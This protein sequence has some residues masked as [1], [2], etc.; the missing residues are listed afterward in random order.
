MSRGIPLTLNSGDH[1][2]QVV[3][4]LV[5]LRA[6]CQ[7][8]LLAGYQPAGPRGYPCQPAPQDGAVA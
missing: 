3:G 7:P 6:G 5:K 1:S 2:A 8:A 4:Q